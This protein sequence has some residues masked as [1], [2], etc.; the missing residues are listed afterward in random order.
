MVIRVVSQ[1]LGAANTKAEQVA[2]MPYQVV[3]ID[4]EYRYG[5]KRGRFEILS[6]H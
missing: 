2:G 6:Q 5:I 4:G 3:A 1:V